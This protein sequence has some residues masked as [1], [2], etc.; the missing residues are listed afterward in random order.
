MRVLHL[1]RDL[2]PGVRGGISVAVG[3][4][5]GA[6][7]R[8]GVP[9]AGISFDDWRPRRRP[10]AGGAPAQSRGPLGEVLRVSSAEHESA[11]LP[12]ARRFGPTVLHVHHGTLW[13]QAA[14]LRTALGVP[15]LITAHVLQRELNAAR[16]FAADTWSALAQ[17][18]ALRSAD[19]VTSPSRWAAD[20]LA[21][22]V[23][24]RVA[25]C[26]P[27]CAVPGVAP[28]GTRT[29]ALLYV[30][31]FDRA[32]GT[33][34][35]LEAWAAVRS[36][37][38]GAA[39]RLAGGVPGN[40]RAE[41]RWRRRWEGNP[42]IELLG[43]LPPDALRAERSAAVAAVAPSHLETFGLAVLEAMAH[44]LPVVATTGHAHAELV[45]HG[46]NGLL[47][48][49]GDREALAAAAVDM[50]ADPERARRW[51]EASW[52]RAQAHRWEQAIVPWIAAWR[53]A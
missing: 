33:E 6:A 48:P 30:G 29:A 2:P 24:R 37:R 8:S 49:V 12:F 27:G 52:Q 44:G 23:G 47:V 22:R 51:G 25:C 3:E 26:P 45:E 32:K 46:V 40:P 19:A 21:R 53:G 39:L 7:V 13:E 35:L 41:R 18:E 1:S 11:L 9:T 31:R 14:R 42:G 5:M 16:G 43:W 20:V 28:Q 17:D 34:D 38:A 50:L 10:G 15:A 36:R 4:L